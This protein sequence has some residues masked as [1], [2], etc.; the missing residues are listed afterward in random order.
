MTQLL[1]HNAMTPSRIGQQ[2]DMTPTIGATF[3]ER[4][5]PRFV[6]TAFVSVSTPTRLLGDEPTPFGGQSRQLQSPARP[7]SSERASAE[8]AVIETRN[9]RLALMMQKF[10]DK[11]STEDNARLML[12]T[13]RLRRLAPIVTAEHVA[14]IEETT[15]VFEKI[16][17][18]L[19]QI[20]ARY[21]A[22]R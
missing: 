5:R 17:D 16:A 1:D 4:R 12:L 19:A 14:Q 22:Y 11:T 2:I 13:D 7:P 18:D 6:E 9:R 21:A 8:D 10:A 3:L 20:Q 15:A